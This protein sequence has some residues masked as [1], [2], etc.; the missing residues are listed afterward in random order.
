L[1]AL[2]YPDR[3]ARR[4]GGVGAPFLMANGRAVTLA[5]DAPLATAQ[6]LVVA[7]AAGSAAGARLL[8][9]AAL[10]PASVERLFAGR[11][12]SRAIFAFDPASGSVTAETRRRLGAITLTRS[13]AERPDPEA[14]A[15][16]LVEGVRVHGLALLPW[17]D[18]ARALR[19]RVAFAR[20]NGM[21]E[22]PDLSDPGLAAS[23]DA[24]LAPLLAGKRRL[25]DLSDS[26]L[27]E[28]LTAS[29]DWSA[30]RALDNFAPTHFTTPAGSHH[31]IDYAA[32][33]GPTVA[34]RVQTLFGLAAHPT[35]A[36][37]VPLTLALT[38]PA[39]RPIQVT[40]DLPRFWA[41]SWADVRRDLRGR[42]PRHPW[43]EDPA[44]ALP[45]LRAKPRQ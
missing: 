34:M 32:E 19:A 44:V 9:G 7:D 42:Y 15:D 17:G 4:R 39:G 8:L 21:A 26:A 6:W 12:E 33:A 37:G 18:T 3:V 11:I 23:L 24:W 28:A 29:L 43:P 2:A 13:P 40:T 36:G 10:D 1:L 41:G 30:R 16:A 35:I 14:L 31:P 27:A 45:T 25:G 5:A 38:S 20:A 22:L